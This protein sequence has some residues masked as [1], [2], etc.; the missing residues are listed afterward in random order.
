MTSEDARDRCLRRLGKFLEHYWHSHR[1]MESN[2]AIR[3][4]TQAYEDYEKALADEDG[5]QDD[6]WLEDPIVYPKHT[7]GDARKTP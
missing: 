4:L 2:E 3:Q 5:P 6:R 7:P 1:E